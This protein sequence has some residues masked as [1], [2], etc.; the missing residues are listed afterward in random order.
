MNATRAALIPFLRLG[1]LLLLHALL[2]EIVPN[3]LALPEASYQARWIVSRL[4]AHPYAA[5]LW[6][7]LAFGLPLLA[8]R[9]RWSEDDLGR[10]RWLVVG[11]A[12]AVALPLWLASTNFHSGRFHGADRLLLLAGVGL[13]ALRPAAVGLVLAQGLLLVGQY[14]YPLGLYFSWT[15][16]RPLW[17]LLLL[18]VIFLAARSVAQSYRAT[19]FLA[20]ALCQVAAMYF[21]AGESKLQTG[22]LAGERLAHL[23]AHA[24]SNGWRPGPYAR[25]LDDA[26]WLDL[27]LRVL[28]LALEMGALLLPLSRRFAPAFLGA[29]IVFH[30][31][32]AALTGSLFWPWIALDVLL[33][34]TIR[35][36]PGDRPAAP[37]APRGFAV[38][39]VALAPW[40][41]APD[42]FGG[43]HA[44]LNVTYEVEAVGASGRTYPVG[45]NFFEPFDS[46]FAEAPFHWLDERPHLTD[47]L[48]YTEDR[49]VV[50]ALEG[51]ADARQTLEIERVRG[52]IDRDPEAAARFDGL[53][54]RRFGALNAGTLRWPLPLDPPFPHTLLFTRLSDEYAG[55]EPVKEVRVHRRSTWH[56]AGRIELLSDEVVRSL[57]IP[58]A[59]ETSE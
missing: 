50:E 30:L 58:S 48:G 37:L 39:V 8:W 20:L 24:F 13:I 16:A 34:A 42:R 11:L 43:M 9:R 57:S 51:A 55:Q 56:H 46:L 53:V 21:W 23:A 27:P 29:A 31:G 3:G 45:R 49:G 1:P 40:I 35:R 25:A 54:A 41:F 19:D 7:G 6:A 33:L 12:A 47:M 52:R 5:L 14:R 15:E 36:L 2:R 38:A 10:L 59:V 4:P 44:P 26:A 22:W 28:T 18:F 17:E 32:V